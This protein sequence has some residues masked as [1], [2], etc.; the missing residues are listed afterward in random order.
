MKYSEA[1]TNPCQ[2]SMQL[3]SEKTYFRLQALVVLTA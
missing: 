2:V 3:K 1:N